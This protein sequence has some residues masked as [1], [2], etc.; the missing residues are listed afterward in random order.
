MNFIKLVLY[1]DSAGIRFL[2]LSFCAGHLDEIFIFKFMIHSIDKKNTV[3]SLLSTY[4]DDNDKRVF[5][6]AELLTRPF[7]G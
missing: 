1:I 7:D 4:L 2:L 6:N 5:L 3:P